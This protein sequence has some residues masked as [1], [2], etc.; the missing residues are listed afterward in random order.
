MQCNVARRYQSALAVGPRKATEN[1]DRVRRP[2]DLPNAQS[3]SPHW[4][5][6][7]MAVSVYKA[8]LNTRFALDWCP[9]GRVRS[10]S[11]ACHGGEQPNFIQGFTNP[12][13]QVAMATKFC[14]VSIFADPQ[15]ANCFISIYRH[16]NFEEDLRFLE[17][18]CTLSKSMS[19]VRLSMTYF[20]H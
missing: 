8:S 9:C 4:Q 14:T 12:R 20:E 2:Q 7:R 18:F 16:Q 10:S 17:N 3:A 13:R 19:R 15:Y 11:E 5:R 6:H 1:L